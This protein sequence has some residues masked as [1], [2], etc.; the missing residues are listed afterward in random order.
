VIQDEAERIRIALADALGAPHTL[1]IDELVDWARELR[2]EFSAVTA[3]YGRQH[4]HVVD[5]HLPDNTGEVA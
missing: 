2:S 4:R 3:R 5:V 1:T